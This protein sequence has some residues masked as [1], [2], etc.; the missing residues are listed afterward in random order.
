MAGCAGCGMGTNGNG[1]PASPG[2]S[3]L[4]IGAG[5]VLGGAIMW[6]LWGREKPLMG[7][8]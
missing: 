3:P 2:V 7:R 1:A 8:L 4:A 5:L 6:L